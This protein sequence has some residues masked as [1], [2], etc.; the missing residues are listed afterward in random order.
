[1][2]VICLNPILPSTWL[3]FK[4]GISLFKYHQQQN[5]CLLDRIENVESQQEQ[6]KHYC[7]SKG[8]NCSSKYFWRSLIGGGSVVGFLPTYCSKLLEILASKYII[9]HK[10]LYSKLFIPTNYR[11]LNCF[12]QTREIC[13][14][15]YIHYT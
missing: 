1:M 3:A 2:N 4:L 13:R 12:L 9:F 10:K 11:G 6:S 7:C 5:L 14:D 8:V 15:N